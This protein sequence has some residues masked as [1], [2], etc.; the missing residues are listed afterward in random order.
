MNVDALRQLV[1]SCRKSKDRFVGRPEM[2][3]PSDWC[4]HKILNPE[5]PLGYYFTDES[6]WEFIACKLESGHPY[7]EVTLNTPPDARAI[8]M[9]IQIK[10]Y[11]SHLYVKVQVG[12]ANKPIGRSFHISY[13]DK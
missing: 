5:M 6:A 7:E 8:V 12:K 10:G 2:G 9:K 11:Q 4:P 13:I 3:L 1:T